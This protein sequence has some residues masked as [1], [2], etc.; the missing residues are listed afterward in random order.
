MYFGLIKNVFFQNLNTLWKT[1]KLWITQPERHF[2]SRNAFQIAQSRMYSIL[3]K[4]I[5]NLSNP[6]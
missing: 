4:Y 3:E 5:M 2:G 1:N 6:K